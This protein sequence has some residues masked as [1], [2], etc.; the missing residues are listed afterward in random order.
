MSLSGM[1]RAL[2][3][4]INPVALPARLDWAA[5]ALLCLDSTAAEISARSAFLDTVASPLVITPGSNVDMVEVAEGVVTRMEGLLTASTASVA[6][7]AQRVAAAAENTTVRIVE[8]I[9]QTSC[10]ANAA[11]RTEV[12]GVR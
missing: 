6:T 3:R 2:A 9:L 8:C 7:S 12:T 1:P 10:R 4:A 5:E 11:S